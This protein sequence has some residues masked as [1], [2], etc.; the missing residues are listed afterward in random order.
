[1]DT[2]KA[3]TATTLLTENNS[4]P[5]VLLTGA[6][7]IVGSDLSRVLLERG[8]KVYAISRNDQSLGHPNLTWVK[9]ALES[10]DEVMEAYKA[11]SPDWV[12]HMASYVSAAPSY[13][14]VMPTFQSNLVSTLHMLMAAKEYG[15]ERMIVAGTSEERVDDVKEILPAS[16]YAAAKLA[17]S[18]YARMFNKLYDVPVCITTLFS[19]YGPT[20][21]KPKRVLPYAI[22]ELLKGKSPEFS[23]GKRRIDWIYA[24]DAIEGLLK[25]IQSKEAEGQTF[26]LGT[27]SMLTIRELI[28]KVADIIGGSGRPVWGARPDRPMENEVA[29]D[30][31]KTQSIIDWQPTV[32]LEEGLKITIDW[33]RTFQ[34]Q[35]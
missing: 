33:Y 17:S 32:G 25:T 8:A 11:I 19:V 31:N 26:D 22:S 1:M 18:A 5:T 4:V 34:Q 20:P 28:D 12:F 15:C 23:S 27:G 24:D 30:L 14:L 35:K 6:S 3:T 21:L 2:T 29:A 7:G 10:K 16:P 13:D 9:L